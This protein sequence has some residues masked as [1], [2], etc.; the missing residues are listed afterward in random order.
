MPDDCHAIRRVPGE[1]QT[2]QSAIAAAEDGDTVFVSAGTYYENLVI[3][4]GNEV[5]LV[6][7]VAGPEQ[8]IIDGRGAGSAVRFQNL[9]TWPPNTG[10]PESRLEGFTITN[11]NAQS[12]GGIRCVNSNPRIYNCRIAGNAAGFVGGGG[13]YGEDGFPLIQNCTVTDNVASGGGGGGMRFYNSTATIRNSIIRANRTAFDGAA[14]FG[15]TGAVSLLNCTVTE[16]TGQSAVA[17]YFGDHNILNSILWADSPL[18]SPEIKL[19]SGTLTVDYSDVQGGSGNVA[20][21]SGDL[22]WRTHNLD[23]DPSFVPGPAGCYD[24]SQT[25]AG[26]GQ[27]SPCVDAGSDIAADLN[28]DT[29]TT[30]SD[31]GT[32]TGI[33]DLGFHY[34]VTGEPLV[35]GDS[36]RDGDLDLL[37]FGDLQAC[38]TG[39][40][41]A[42]VS[43]CCRLFDFEPDADVDWDDYAAFQAAFTGPE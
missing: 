1:F 43:P 12:G 3:S 22:I 4:T 2:I 8:T 38:F 11:G 34:P 20:V 23:V 9:Q 35:M 40:G 14:I 19:T 37:D 24:L 39:I 10:Q 27:Q 6:K 36:D 42:E 25:A 41:P 29:M 15:Q 32:D 16:N 31:E 28:L 26:Q 33:A 7:S 18:Q 17:F 30:R 5:I 13:I 21:D